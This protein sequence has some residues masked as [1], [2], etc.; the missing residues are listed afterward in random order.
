MER[1]PLGPEE[2]CGC[3]SEDQYKSCCLPKGLQWLVGDD[4][5]IYRQVKVDGEL[6]KLLDELKRKSKPG[7][8][9]FPPE[10]IPSPE[11]MRQILTQAGVSPA[12]LYAWEKTGMMLTEQNKH[13]WPDVDLAAWDAAITEHQREEEI[14][15][16][17]TDHPGTTREEAREF[18]EDLEAEEASME[19]ENQLMAAGYGADV[20]CAYFHL[21]YVVLPE[22]R[23]QFTDVQLAAWDREIAA[24]TGSPKVSEAVRQKLLE[25]ITRRRPKTAH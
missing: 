10:A 15:A 22:N 4:G 24:Y 20:A 9:L 6:A 14:D 8:P 3:G 16:W 18:F 12:W 7:D 25:D 23:G 17:V 5:S 2:H 13:Q 11:I 19:V 21:G 1:R